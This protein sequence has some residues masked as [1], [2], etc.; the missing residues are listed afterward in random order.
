MIVFPASVRVFLWY[1]VTDLA[2]EDRLR[3]RQAESRPL[4]DAIFSL[5]EGILRKET[6]QTNLGG[7]VAAYMFRLK[8]PLT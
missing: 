2:P 4:V 1:G 6:Q 7:V 3:I 8:E 5:A